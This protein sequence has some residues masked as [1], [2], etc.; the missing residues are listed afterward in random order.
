VK[1]VALRYFTLEKHGKSYIILAKEA[2]FQYIRDSA[3]KGDRK[4]E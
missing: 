3:K 2:V 4:Y 1:T